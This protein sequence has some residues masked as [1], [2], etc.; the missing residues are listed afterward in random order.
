MF[1]EETRGIKSYLV[2][3]RQLGESRNELS[4]LHEEQQ[5]LFH[6]VTH[7]VYV[8]YLL[9]GQVTVIGL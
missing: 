7:I 5:L 8:S 9:I 2:V 6:G 3:Q 4:P 1:C